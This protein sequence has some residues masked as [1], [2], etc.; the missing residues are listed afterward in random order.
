[1][2]VGLRRIVRLKRQGTKKGLSHSKEA[3]V[4]KTTTGA[5]AT[6]APAGTTGWNSYDSVGYLNSAGSTTWISAVVIRPSACPT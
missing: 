2:T 1:M 3:A 6:A 4:L 5:I